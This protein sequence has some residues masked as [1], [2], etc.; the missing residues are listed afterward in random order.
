[1]ILPYNKRYQRLN[2]NCRTFCEGFIVSAFR[3]CQLY[4][5]IC[6]N[7]A[8]Q[9]NILCCGSWTNKHGFHIRIKLKLAHNVGIGEFGQIEATTGFWEGRGGL[10]RTAWTSDFVMF[11]SLGGFVI[12]WFRRPRIWQTHGVQEPQQQNR[13]SPYFDMFEVLVL[14]IMDFFLLGAGGGWD[15]F[16]DIFRHSRSSS[17]DLHG[18]CFKIYDVQGVLCYSVLYFVLLMN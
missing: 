18:R 7:A 12:L 5:E 15:L 3:H 14:Q 11:P 13:A 1:M 9:I 8:R 17:G 6:S 10:G 16:E 4:G 2:L